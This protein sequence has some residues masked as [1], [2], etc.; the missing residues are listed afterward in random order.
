MI[1]VFLAFLSL[2]FLT[3]L[4]LNWEPCFPSWLRK[5]IEAEAAQRLPAKVSIKRAKLFLFAGLL[6]LEGIEAK[7][8]EQQKATIARLTVQDPLA[9]LLR[10][11]VLSL[12]AENVSVEKSLD[13]LRALQEQEKTRS[14]SWMLT[15]ESAHIE[16]PGQSLAHL[17]PVAIEKALLSF[18][19]GQLSITEVQAQWGALADL[20]LIDDVGGSGQSRLK[21]TLEAALLKSL[22]KSFQCPWTPVLDD[23]LKLDA[24]IE[25]ERKCL[26]V[27]E[28]KAAWDLF[29]VE[30]SGEGA[31][32]AHSFSLRLKS[33]LTP[34]LA[35]LLNRGLP[36]ERQL[37]DAAFERLPK[38]PISVS[39]VFSWAKGRGHLSVKLKTEASQLEIVG[40]DDSANIWP[41]TIEGRLLG[42]DLLGGMGFDPG[43]ID[44]G[45]AQLQLKMVASREEHWQLNGALSCPLLKLGLRTNEQSEGRLVYSLKNGAVDFTLDPSELSWHKLSAEF[46]GGSLEKGEGRLCLSSKPLSYEGTVDYKDLR[47]EHWP[48]G[49]EGQDPGLSKILE[50]RAH[51]WFEYRG[52]LER[53]GSF[54]GDGSLTVE[55]ANYTF[56]KDIREWAGTLA[57]PLPHQQGVKEATGTLLLEDG[58]FRLEDISAPLVGVKIN[59]HWGFDKN[60]QVDALFKVDVA[61]T[62]LSRSPLLILPA[63]MSGSLD[64]EVIGKGTL[65]KPSFHPDLKIFDKLMGKGSGEEGFLGRLLRG[66]E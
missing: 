45:R 19:Q 13:W 14:P 44:V 23:P 6:I 42:A 15:V 16:A 54:A 28:V 38:S 21:M 41:L 2:M 1:Y 5:R 37:P 58:G 36:K 10:G 56:L 22:L 55:E 50:G 34:A 29:Q 31:L 52:Q 30:G 66:F 63:F 48:T 4:L 26:R 62:F 65:T 3:L 12:R 9:F 47:I 61:R 11:A 60:Q 53:P 7:A 20:S 32:E 51:G 46:L 64:F 17:G 33:E 35:Q 59:G 57:L 27:H 49:V 39:A 25:F 24:R 18:D 43:L 8:G 40:F